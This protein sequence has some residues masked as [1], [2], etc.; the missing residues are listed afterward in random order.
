MRLRAASCD[1]AMRERRRRTPRRY[2]RETSPARRH[3]RTRI[4]EQRHSNSVRPLSLPPLTSGTCAGAWRTP[5]PLCDLVLTRG[6]AVSRVQDGATAAAVAA[7]G[8][9][10]MRWLL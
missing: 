10:Q 1:L 5:H 2:S 6:S 3:P 8:M 7:A 4:G 9:G